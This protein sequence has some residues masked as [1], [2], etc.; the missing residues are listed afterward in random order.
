M[1]GLVVALSA[2]AATGWRT[3]LV[4]RRVALTLLGV[5]ATTLVRV[6]ALT[7]VTTLRRIAALLGVAAALVLV[8]PC[9][10]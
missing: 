8:A 1:S 4:R 2:I 9:S 5:A 7:G 6:A 10:G 3:L